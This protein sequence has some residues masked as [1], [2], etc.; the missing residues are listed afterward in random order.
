MSGRSWF[1]LTCLSLAWVLAATLIQAVSGGSV[2]TAEDLASSATETYTRPD[3]VSASI[4][5]RVLDQRVED[6]SQRTETTVVYANPNG[7]WTSDEASEPVR[8]ESAPGEWHDVDTTLIERNGKLEPRYAVTDL[9]LSDGGER[10]FAALTADDRDLSWQWSEA[11]PEPTLDGDTAT[12]P[13]VIEGGDLVVT[14]TTTGFTHS[15]VLN[16]R[17]TEPLE[18]TMPVGLDGAKLIESQATGTLTVKAP[19]GDVIASAPR[20]MMWDATE[21]QGGTPENVAPV[22]AAVTLTESGNTRLTLSPDDAFLSDP[23][24]QYPVTVDPGYSVYTT[25]DTWIMNAD[26]SGSQHT[27]QELRAGTY[28]AGG[29][30]ARSLIKFDVSYLNGRN[31]TDATL[32]LRNWDSASCTAGALRAYRVTANWS[33]TGV[34]WANQPAVSSTAYADYS[35][36]HGYTGCA[37]DNA[38]WNVTSIVEDWTESGIANYGLRIRGA[39][40]TSSNTWRKYRSADYTA[41]PVYAPRLITTYNTHPGTATKPA[42][43]PGQVYTPSGGSAQIY[44]DDTTPKFNSKAYDGDGGT[45]RI[46]FEVHTSTTVS[47]G[48]L[49]SEC[50]TSSFTQGTN[51]GCALASGDALTNGSTYYVRAK[52]YDGINWAGG[53]EASAT[54]WS[55]WV[56]LKV[57]TTNPT[58]TTSSSS[59][60]NGSW[61]TS[62]PTSSTFTFNGATDTASVDV[63]IDGGAHTSHLATNTSGDATL[64]WP[65]TTGWHTLTATATDRAGNAAVSTFKF[66]ANGA[67]FTTP[68]ETARSTSAFDLNLTAPPG[69]TGAT[70][71]WRL[72]T[73]A[74]WLTATKLTR[75][76]SAWNSAVINTAD[77][78]STGNLLWDATSESP[79]GVLV[80][81]AVVE[82]RGCFHFASAAD[83]CTP[84]RT[85]QLVPSAFGDNFPVTDLGPASVALFTGEATISSVDAADSQA[86]IGRTFSSYDASTTHA[87]A[88]GL[89]WSAPSVLLPGDGTDATIIDKRST[90]DSLVLVNAGSGSQTF[91][92]A[93]GSTTKYVPLVSTGDATA[94]TF[95]TGTPDTLTLERPVGSGSVIT[96]WE[97]TTPEGSDDPQWVFVSLNPVGAAGT[98]T[99][100]NDHQ[101]P[102][103]VQESDPAVSGDCN[104]ITQTVGCRGLAITYSGTGSQSRVTSIA[105]VIGADD[106]EEPRTRTLATYTYDGSDRLA[107]ACSPL[108]VPE[109][110]PLC[111]T[112]AYTVVAGHTLISE[113][114]PAGLK[115][116]RLTY[117]TTG[118]LTTVKRE[119]PTGGDSTW[120]IDYGLNPTSSGLPDLSASAA[121]EWGQTKIPT[122]VFAVYEPY[123]G[124]ADVIKANLFYTTDDGTITNTASHGPSSWLVDTIWHNSDGNLIQHLDATGWSRVQA[125]A[126][127]DRASVAAD[128][129]SY[130]IYNTWGDEDVVGT[131]V[132]DEYGPAHTASLMD[133]TTGLFRTHTHTMYDDSPDVDGSLVTATHGADNLGVVVK[134]VRSTSDATRATDYDSVATKYGYEPIVTGDGN[135]WTL[136]IATTTSVQVDANTWSTH[137]TRFDT[138]GRTIESRQPGGASDTTSAGSDAHST[139]TTYY[140]A[141]TTGDCGGH[142]EWIGQVCKIGPAAQLPSR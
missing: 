40:E 133:G 116:W 5:A 25:G 15:I 41:N 56:T 89:G 55:P 130:T 48:T 82:L 18:F 88:F 53:S 137:T 127:A 95:S 129:S 3:S 134:E 61:N 2:A 113:I 70:V 31:V 74:T 114:T 120:S 98:L 104:A 68:E 83:N 108:P 139:Q 142:P 111:T 97:W 87:G 118:R 60:T 45:V 20:P 109:G 90:Q 9:A 77:Q 81:P 92:L 75:D 115:K 63:V 14:A 33:L 131:R 126:V 141:A 52:A 71:E 47:S 76:G 21:D 91:V 23:D 17:P 125:A 117:D 123:I 62:P 16:E 110:S 79:A 57:D 132:V 67:G 19:D 11:L 26:F 102:T 84:V 22:D 136:G 46:N 85:V 27:S 124:A 105:R 30:I 37:E 140:T 58:I 10:T 32:R 135:G 7:S 119:R 34:T 54:G 107:S 39:S 44:T 99:V 35:P 100:T 80:A 29:H 36:A 72:A 96:K 121:G 66:G 50:T 49:R 73:Q 65:T 28:D 38:Y 122:K 94:L 86:G 78:S 59:F 24:T 64:T 12:Y 128:A 6:L 93:P 138:E 42:V 103:F 106:P 1:R 101:R 69:A 43:T 4:A 8:V 13:E 51:A 112:Y